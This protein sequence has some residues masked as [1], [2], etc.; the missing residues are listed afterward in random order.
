MNWYKIANSE[1]FMN[2]PGVFWHGSPSGDLRGSSNGLH[3]GTYEA[4]KQ[5]LEARIGIPAEG[6]WDGT[7][8][9]GKTLLAGKQRIESINPYGV[10]GYNCEAPNED[11]YP[12]G[13]ATYGDGTLIP[14]TVK[15]NIIPVR[16][17]GKMTNTP[18]NPH[19]D[20]KANGL[21][22]GQISRGKAKSG[23][24]YKNEGEDSGSIS[25]VLPNGTH[26]ERL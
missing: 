19:E 5:A 10:T 15:P 20:F 23:Y 11:Y 2:M 25:A 21:M 7:R 12:T 16:I 3:V 9:Y 6:T 26:I 18:N 24:Y 1:Q 14:L 4:A 13:R 22:R 8:E 17:T